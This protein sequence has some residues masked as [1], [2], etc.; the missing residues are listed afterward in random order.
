MV[1]DEIKVGS[2][3]RVPTI[4]GPPK[5]ITDGA[6]SPPHRAVGHSVG[7]LVPPN[8]RVSRGPGH[9]DGRVGSP[10]VHPYWDSGSSSRPIYI[11]F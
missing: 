8:L 5:T 3:L 1:G 9:V 6:G 2:K 10:S 7:E 4:G 11:P